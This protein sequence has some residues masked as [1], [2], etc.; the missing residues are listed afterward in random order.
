MLD[1]CL[2]C[3]QNQKKNEVINN[4]KKGLKVTLCEIL[5]ACLLIR[6]SLSDWMA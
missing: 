6:S 5:E 2:S 3:N 1:K 4:L